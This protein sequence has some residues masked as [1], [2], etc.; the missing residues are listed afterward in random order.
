MELVSHR[1]L[2]ACLCLQTVLCWGV[3]RPDAWDPDDDS[4]QETY[5]NS[6]CALHGACCS[7]VNCKTLD[8]SPWMWLLYVPFSQASVH[9]RIKLKCKFMLVER[10][11]VMHW[12]FVRE[13]GK[14]HNCLWDLRIWQEPC[15]RIWRSH[16][17]GYEEYHLLGYNAM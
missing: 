8:L 14:D 6:S 3:W 7:F 2:R 11:K 5:P 13:N 1:I 16:S 15:C 17:G 4:D 9:C 10:R 12:N